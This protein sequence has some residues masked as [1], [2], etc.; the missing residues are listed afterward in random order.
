MS[1]SPVIYAYDTVALGMFYEIP[2][3]KETSVLTCEIENL[4]R[5][6]DVMNL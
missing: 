6:S 5:L 3:F 2:E 4:A 1:P